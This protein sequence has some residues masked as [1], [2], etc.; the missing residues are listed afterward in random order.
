MDQEDKNMDGLIER[1]VKLS[2]NSGL[3]NISDIIRNREAMSYEDTAKSNP[4]LLDIAREVEMKKLAYNDPKL[5]DASAD[6]LIM[7][8]GPKAFTYVSPELTSALR[9]TNTVK[10]ND[11]MRITGIP[12]RKE[13]SNAI[14]DNDAM[15]RLKWKITGNALKAN[16]WIDAQ[17][18]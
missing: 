7:A 6:M 5:R 16:A 15:E 12:T 17:N 8:Q 1:N 14:Q 2:D 13:I 11:P 3:G 9:V 10:T 18:R 4:M